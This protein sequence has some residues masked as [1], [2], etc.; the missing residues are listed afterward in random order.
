MSESGHGFFGQRVRLE[1]ISRRRALHMG[2]LLAVFVWGTVVLYVL[3]FVPDREGLVLCSFKHLTGVACPTCGGLRQASQLMEGNVWGA[4]LT[5]PLLLVAGCAVLA[6]LVLRLGF[7]RT[8]HL[9]L[10]DEARRQVWLWA[11]AVF[12]ANWLYVIT[13]VG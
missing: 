3:L 4:F 11:G 5:N 12:L 6:V 1:R 7:G 2:P 8:L 9:E 10:S 13:W